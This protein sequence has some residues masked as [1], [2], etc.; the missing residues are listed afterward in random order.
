MKKQAKLT[1]RQRELRRY[2]WNSRTEWVSSKQ[3]FD[4]VAGYNSKS[5]A[6]K[7]INEDVH[8]INE[9]GEYDKIIITDRVLGYK[10]ATKKQFEDWAKRAYA[11][12]IRKIVYVSRLIK[13]AKMDD[14]GI[15]PGIEG[16]QREFYDKFVEEGES[17]C[18][19][20]EVSSQSKSSIVTAS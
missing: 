11:E 5:T 2:L 3:I 14:Q 7:Q 15:I 16:Y 12:S 4:N 18:K 13:D 9:S 10:L 20:K 19:R 17:A 8:A 1:P 6:Y